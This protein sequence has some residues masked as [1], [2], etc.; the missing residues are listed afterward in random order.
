LAW[1]LIICGMFVVRKVKWR[2]LFSPSIILSLKDSLLGNIYIH[3]CI[4]ALY[5]LNGNSLLINWLKLKI[6]GANTSQ[7]ELGAQWWN[8]G[9]WLGQS[10][11]TVPWFWWPVID[12]NGQVCFWNTMYYKAVWLVCKFSPLHHK[13]HLLTK[14]DI[15]DQMV[16]L[17]LKPMNSIFWTTCW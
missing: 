12:R 10:V 14:S 17:A 16:N 9:N 11:N 6:V 2:H 3:G 15:A 5:W 13:R 8:E 7:Q 4:I 1:Q